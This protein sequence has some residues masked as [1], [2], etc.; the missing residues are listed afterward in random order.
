MQEKGRGFPNWGYVLLGVL[1]FAGFYFVKNMGQR[2]ILKAVLGEPADLINKAMSS[3]RVSPRIT[4]RTGRITAKNFKMEKLGATKDSLSFRFFLDG[5]RAD[6]TV[7]L[8]MARRPSG[9]WE[10]VKSDTTY[11]E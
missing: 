7:R 5:E 10:I 3:A 8:W 2:T 4:N 9:E 11:T 6:A 1:A